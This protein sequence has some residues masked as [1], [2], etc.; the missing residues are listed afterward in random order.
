MVTGQQKNYIHRQ[1]KIPVLDRCEFRIDKKIATNYHY[2]VGAFG[3]I[4]GVWSHDSTWIAYTQ[5]TKAYIQQV[6]VY[7]LKKN[8]SYGITDGL[9]EVSEPVFDKSGKY[10]FFFAS[11]NA[12]P[13]VNWF[14]MSNADMDMTN[15]IY[16]VTLR[17]DIPSP[18]AKESDE[19][20]EAEEKPQKE[21][22]KKDKPK[23]DEKKKEEP[24]SIDFDS[25]NHHILCLPIDDGN[26]S[27]LQVGEEG[28]IYYLERLA[29]GRDTQL[30]KF[31]LK[32]KKNEVIIPKA[33][34]YWLSADNKKILYTSARSWGIVS[35]SSKMKPGEGKL[36]VEAIQVRIDPRSEWKQ[37]FYE[38]W[39][40]NR[41]YFYA[42]NYHGADW[43]AMQKKYAPF[44]PHLSC[45]SDLNRVIRWMC[46][47]I[48]VGHHRVGGGDV[49]SSPE[50]VPGGLLGAYFAIEKGRY[51]IKKVYG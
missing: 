24:L 26:F 34:A 13:V 37:I 10:L 51:R 14:A 50:R 5:H 36:N 30:H 46:S 42:T 33:N 11:T 49:L 31:T 6:Y 23:K 35:S 17:N 45:R 44:L 18:L 16:L 29:L 12:G 7:S 48:G 3:I 8:K 47:E 22:A 19:E 27:N 39:R 28:V 2:G 1:R 20:K 4:R 40:I 32:D 9:S 41:D 21:K 25:L 43:K 15:S 38:A